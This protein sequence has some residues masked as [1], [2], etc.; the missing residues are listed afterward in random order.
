MK[1]Y[2]QNEIRSIVR[3]AYH[4]GFKDATEGREPVW[5]KVANVADHELTGNIASGKFKENE[6]A[7]A[8]G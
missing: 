2:T 7:E 6:D 8:I 1:I 5:P 3:R 4:L